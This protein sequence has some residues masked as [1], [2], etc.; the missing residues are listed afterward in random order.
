MNRSSVLPVRLLFSLVFSLFL[1]CVTRAPA[2]APPPTGRTVPEREEPIR[3]ELNDWWSSAAA[4]TSTETWGHSEFV[5]PRTSC[6]V[7][8]DRWWGLPPDSGGAAHEESSRIVTV[9]GVPL[10]FVNFSLFE[11]VAQRVDVLFLRYA[12]G[13]A[14]VA[15]RECAPTEEETVLAGAKLSPA[16]RSTVRP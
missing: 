4:A 1:G 3:L 14:R 5:A 8:I 2:G 11:G 7:E 13:H 16:A 9:D 10:R 6:K 15:F 12:E